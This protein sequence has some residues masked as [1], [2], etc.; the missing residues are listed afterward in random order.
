M[1]SLLRSV[2]VSAA[3]LAAVEEECW[4]RAEGLHQS[5]PHSQLQSPSRYVRVT[6]QVL[7]C[8]STVRA[9]RDFWDLSLCRKVVV[10]DFPLQGP[11]ANRP[12]GQQ[13]GFPLLCARHRAPLPPPL[14]KKSSSS[15]W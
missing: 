1:L 12:T 8:R 7:T 11:S 13:L 5:V 3:R 10:E 15:A 9:E 14:Y 4:A 6:H 2:P